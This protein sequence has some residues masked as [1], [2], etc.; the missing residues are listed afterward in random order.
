MDRLIWSD[1]FDAKKVVK[2]RMNIITEGESVYSDAEFF[3]GRNF[4][5]YGY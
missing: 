1:T 5:D 2:S 3:E 4:V